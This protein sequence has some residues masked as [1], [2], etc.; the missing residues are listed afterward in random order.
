MTGNMD[1]DEAELLKAWGR[2]LEKKHPNRRREG[3]P[4]LQALNHLASM[5]IDLEIAATLDHVDRCFP[6]SEEL[7]RLR[8]AAKKQR[9]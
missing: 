1:A 5:S 9:P 8:K 2:Y 7:R 4:G 3:C 6:C